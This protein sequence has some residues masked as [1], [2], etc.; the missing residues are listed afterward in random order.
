M[1]TPPCQGMSTAGQQEQDDERNR[2]IIPVINAVNILKPNYVFIE[3]VPNFLNT[4]IQI[5]G[6]NILIPDYI[7]AELGQ[8]YEIHSYTINTKNYSVPQV[9]ERA[10][11]LITKKG[12]SN[13][14]LLPEPDEK[15]ITMRKSKR[16]QCAQTTCSFAKCKDFNNRFVLY[17]S[18]QRK[19][20]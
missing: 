15:I 18:C 9:R 4:T 1:A 12:L 2:L 20:L 16:H 8:K 6:T 3:N 14:W 5:N 13:I 10:I 7:N 11:F 19:L 17:R